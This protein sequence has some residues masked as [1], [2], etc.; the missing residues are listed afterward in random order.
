MVV[1]LFVVLQIEVSHLGRAGAT[2]VQFCY[3]T[4]EDVR[5]NSSLSFGSISCILISLVS[6]IPIYLTP[7]YLPHPHIQHLCEIVLTCFA[8]HVRS[9][10]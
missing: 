8:T 3:S 4:C 6:L 5:I 1:V 2:Y 7:R 9:R 10:R